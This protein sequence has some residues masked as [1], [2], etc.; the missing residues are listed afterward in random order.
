MN[1]LSTKPFLKNVLTIAKGTAMGQVILFAASPILSRLYTP[2]E[3]GVLSIYTIS[4]S[5]LSIFSTLKLELAMQTEEDD[6]ASLLLKIGLLANLLFSILLAAL[7]L[8]QLEPVGQILGLSEPMY[9]LFIPLGVFALGLYK[10][11]SSIFIREK[12]FDRTKSLFITNSFFTVLI[13]LGLGLTKINGLVIGDALGRNIANVGA[14]KDS[15]TKIMSVKVSG[16]SILKNLK[17]KK[18]YVLFS[19]TSEFL[20]VLV[21]QSLP[22][23]LILFFNPVLAGLYSFGLKIVNAPMILIGKSISQAYLSEIRSYVKSPEKIN[24]LFNQLVNK[25]ALVG[26]I[27]YL[28]LLF[29]GPEIFTLVF[30]GQWGDAGKMMSIMAMYFFVELVMYPLMV[31]LEILEQQSYLL[32]WQILRGISGLAIFYIGYSLNV[33]VYSI[34]LFSS[35]SFIVF[36]IGM[37]IYIKKLLRSKEVDK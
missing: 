5:S 23:L 10:V 28:V 21:N 16:R 13:Q 35:L 34:L 24:A 18:D 7:L 14:F 29:W 20:F 11:N 12:G 32:S 1:V 17:S 15:F 22:F 6:Q 33:N 4:I 36:Y 26:A 8:W 27:P 30:G 19:T 2:E 25:L 3:Y 9:L 31:T 37:Y